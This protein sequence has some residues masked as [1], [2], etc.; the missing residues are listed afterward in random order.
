VNPLL[1]LPRAREVFGTAGVDAMMATTHA[2]VRYLSGFVGFGQRL[3]PS[4]Q[5]YALAHLE[6]L[7]ESTVI[8]PAGELDM[9]AQFPPVEARLAP[10]GRFFVEVQSDGAALS[11]EISRYRS[12]VDVDAQSSSLSAITSHLDMLG[13]KAKIGLD[14]RGIAATARDA[15][16][17]RYG[18]R[19]IDAAAMFDQVRMV[20]TPEEVRRLTRATQVIEAAFQRAIAEAR[21]GMSEI[22]MALVFDSETIRLGCEPVFTVL[23]FGE[24]SALPNAMP[25]DR[26]LRS[27]DII[28]F[29]IGCRTEGYYSDIARTAIFG[30]ATDKQRTY[31]DAILEGERRAIE[32]VKAGVLANE[33]FATAVEATRKAGIP[34]Y[35]RHHVGHGIGL[36]VYDL[37]IL[38]DSTTTELEPGMVLEVETPYYEL[39]FGGLQVEDTILVTEGG[40]RRLTGSSSELAL[41]G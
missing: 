31:Y 5:V 19:L 17:S 29:D 39:G 25:G 28:R 11:D 15:L 1:N 32:D 6:K 8:L 21:E 3:M 12:L 14:E 16:R 40:H 22:E 4:T 24:R 27:G 13:P 36:D 35:R 9:W 7:P 23:A 10:Y 41:V 26:A 30:D 38:N 33:I 2:N 37:P 34:H 18:A 20:K